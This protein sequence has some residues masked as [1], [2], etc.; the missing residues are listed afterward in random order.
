MKINV[1]LSNEFGWRYFCINGYNL[2]FKGYLMNI[3]LNRSLDHIQILCSK[4][5]IDLTEIAEWIRNLRGHFAIVLYDSEKLFCCVDHVRSIPLLYSHNANEISISSNTTNVSEK[6][7]SDSKDYNKL[8]AIE[9]AMSGYTIGNKTLYSNIFQLQAGEC[10]IAH[11]NKITVKCYYC[12]SPWNIV[13]KDKNFFK[14]ELNKILRHVL[15]DLILSCRDRQIIIPLSGGYDSR[16]IVSGLKEMGVKDVICFSYGL[17]NNF[18]AKTAEKIATKLG[19]K[20][21]YVPMSI[22]GQKET[23]SRKS[24]SQFWRYSDNYCNSPVLIDYSAVKKLIDD[25]DIAKDAIFINGNS[26]DFI[27]GG[28]I[29]SQNS[30]DLESGIDV[31]IDS[32]L[33]KHFSLWRALRLV[34]N[35]NKIQNQLRKIILDTVRNY[36]LSKDLSGLLGKIL[37]GQAGKVNLSRQHKEAMNFMITNGGSLFG[38]QCL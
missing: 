37:S 4:K 8:A 16:L 13:N 32:I 9:I 33:N 38:I 31:L 10:L 22:K 7:V 27:T 34:C 5:D 3:N 35:D 29:I 6:S 21:I 20:Y 23:F 36:S 26:G 2:W 25:H 19:Y 14:D 1:P 28:H 12:Y 15:E 18:E 11:R 17:S 30:N 24:F